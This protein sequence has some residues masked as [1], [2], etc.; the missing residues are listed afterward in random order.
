MTTLHFPLTLR[1]KEGRY[2]ENM[3]TVTISNTSLMAVEVAFYFQHDH[4]AQTFLLEPPNM[5]LDAG[6]SKVNRSRLNY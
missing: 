6:E 5:A 2:P 1:Y 4:N 3:E